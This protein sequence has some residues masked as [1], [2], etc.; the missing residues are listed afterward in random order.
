VVPR[1]IIIALAVALFAA[2]GFA[3]AKGNRHDIA[4]LGLRF[5]WAGGMKLTVDKGKQDTLARGEAGGLRF[6]AVVRL[7]ERIPR[8]QQRFRLMSYWPGQWDKLERPCGGK[9]WGEGCA[10]WEWDA[11]NGKERGWAVTGHGP[12]GTYLILL[13]VPRAKYEKMLPRIRRLEGS[14][15][16]Y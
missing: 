7:G 13:A 6:E 14:I 5:E 8:D 9:G 15:E 2:S 4:E 10:V 11:E 12:K 1:K 3:R 16:L